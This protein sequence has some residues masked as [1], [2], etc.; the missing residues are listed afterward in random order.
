MIFWSN[1]YFNIIECITI[2]VVVCI[3]WMYFFY[4]R[5]FQISWT[6]KHLSDQIVLHLQHSHH[7]ADC[8]S[9]Q[10][11]FLFTITLQT[12]SYQ[13][14]HWSVRQMAR[15]WRFGSS[16]DSCWWIRLLYVFFTW[17]LFLCSIWLCV[18]SVCCTDVSPPHTLMEIISDP[19]HA[20]FYLLFILI[21]CALFSK[22]WIEVS[23]SAPR[24]IAKQFKDQG[25][26]GINGCPW[27]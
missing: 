13:L 22:T 18:Y 4:S 1:L 15:Y 9:L 8:I 6:T 20:L 23:G 27:I 26:H 11:I 25:I 14:S 21:T 10:S 2:L 17:S 3:L 5:I 19:V 12:L 7:S 24:D 16:D